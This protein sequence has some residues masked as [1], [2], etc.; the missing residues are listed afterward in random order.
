MVKGGSFGSPYS[1]GSPSPISRAVSFNAVAL[2][3][4]RRHRRG[5]A[6][7]VLGGETGRG[8]VVNRRSNGMSIGFGGLFEIDF[9]LVPTGTEAH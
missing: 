9:R 3:R 2:P 8:Q 1:Y 7:A 5:T 6:R 4:R